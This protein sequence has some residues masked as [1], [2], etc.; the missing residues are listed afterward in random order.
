MDA[1]QS[2]GI[3]MGCKP[4]SITMPI[5]AIIML[6]TFVFILGSTNRYGPQ[7]VAFLIAY[8]ISLGGAFILL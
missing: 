1:S 4:T 3:S 6:T 7:F 8:V 2:Q 5:F